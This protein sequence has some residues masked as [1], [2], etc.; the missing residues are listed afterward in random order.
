MS[1][2]LVNVGDSLRV[3]WPD[4]DGSSHWHIAK[5]LTIEKLKKLKR[6]SEY[7]YTLHFDDGDIIKSTLVN[8]KW[9]LMEAVGTNDAELEVMKE[10]KDTNGIHTEGKKKK[11]K[12]GDKRTRSG[13]YEHDAVTGMGLENR[14]TTK[15]SKIEHKYNTKFPLPPHKY[16]CAP[17]VGASELAFR[18]LCRRYGTQLAYTPMMNSELFAIDEDYRNEQFQCTSEDRPIVAHFSGNNPEVIVQAAKHVE[19]RCDAI[20]LNLG[21]PQRIAY[22]GKFGSFLL[23]EEHRDTVL[24]MVRALSHS[25]RLPIFVKIR[26]LDTVPDTIRLCQQLVEAGASLIAI[27]ARYRVDL[28]LR[29]GPGARDGPAHLDQVEQIKKVVDSIPI[30]ANG[31]VITWEDVERNLISTGADGI[32]SAEGLLDNP[33]LFYPSSVSKDVSVDK[34]DLAIEYLDLVNQYPVKM[35]CLIFHIRRMCKVELNNYQLLE[36]CLSSKTAQDVRDVI[37]KAIEYRDNPETFEYDPDK[38]AKAKQLAARKKFEEGKR[39][40]FEERMI[41]K[42]KREGLEDLNFYLNQGSEPPSLEEIEAMKKL[43][44]DDQFAMWKAQFSQHC[45]PYHFETCT[46][47]RACAFLHADASLGDSLSFG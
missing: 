42:A 31:N 8:K 21:C 44:K 10:I 36:D 45:Y 2:P 4:E 46:R 30:I 37:C 47:D 43:D 19:N 22:A 28:T 5:V 13:E 25:I 18:L 16:I 38:E 39:K 32:M 27:H 1:A 26:L 3:N 7:R 29:T 40:R 12:K 11:K 15:H 41:R 34:L 33:A 24:S 35:K 20:D 14:N 17:M 23:A 6:G 9:E